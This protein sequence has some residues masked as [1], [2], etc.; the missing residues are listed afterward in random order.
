MS[1]C[2]MYSS[3]ACVCIQYISHL[4]LLHD[5]DAVGLQHGVDAVCDGEGGASLERLPDGGL[6][7]GVGLGIDG[8]CGFV[9][10]DDL[11]QD[12]EEV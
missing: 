5:Q 8:C 6:D 12:M 4:S 10:E 11:R 9:Q 1:M 2:I 7:Q 3:S